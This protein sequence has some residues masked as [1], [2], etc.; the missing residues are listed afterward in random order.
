MNNAVYFLKTVVADADETVKEYLDIIKHEIDGSQRI[1]T[2][3]LDFARTKTPEARP[4]VVRGLV[5][6][7]LGRCPI[8]ENIDVQTDIPDT[9]PQVNVDPF[10]MGQVLQNLI[11]N[12]VQAMP[13]GG[14]LTVAARRVPRHTPQSAG[15]DLNPE[16]C[17]LLPGD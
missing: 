4:V 10:Q 5:T 15:P 14:T 16:T 12:A 6:E 9:L 7:S 1:I 13:E 17:D 2:D 3:L 8:P 11:T